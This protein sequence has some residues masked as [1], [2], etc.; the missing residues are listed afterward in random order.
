MGEG[1][2]G[3]RWVGGRGEEG[4]WEGEGRR[5]GR[6]QG[7]I[8]EEWRG[9]DGRWESADT[10]QQLVAY[11]YTNACHKGAQSG[12]LHSSVIVICACGSCYNLSFNFPHA[13]GQEK[14]CIT[15]CENSTL[16]AET[17]EIAAAAYSTPSSRCTVCR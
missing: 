1:V 5:M 7:R 8:G 14:C 3:G 2:E 4:G 6:R 13:W 11:H 16:H 15:K 9:S 17:N 10:M 12:K